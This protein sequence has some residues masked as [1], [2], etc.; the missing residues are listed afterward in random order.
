MK[1][2]PVCTY[3]IQLTP[4]FRFSDA[5]PLMPYFAALGV[6]HIYTSPYLQASPGSTH[7]YDVVDPLSVNE[8][9][10]GKEGHR[11]FLRSLKKEGL[12][13]LIDIVPNHM[14]I[15]GP[16]NRWWWDVLENGPSSPYAAFFDVDW[17]PPEGSMRNRIL[18]PVLEDHYGLV[19]E[20]G[21]VS[22]TREGADFRISYRDMIFPV[23]PRS[24]SGIMERV[25]KEAGHG[26]MLFLAYSLENLP[27]PS[28]TDHESTSLRHRNI[29]VIRE[30]L[31]RLLK[32]EHDLE[33]I[34]DRVIADINE[35]IDAL[36]EMLEKQNYRL[37]FWRKAR[38]DL[39]YRRFF[40]I[41]SLVG[42]RV[43]DERVFRE[44][45]A[46]IISWL[47]EGV[48]D[49]L[50]VDHPDGLRDP[51]EYFSR[52]VERSPDCWIL[53]EK[54]LV[55]GEK[56]RKSWSIH[57][58]TGYDFLNLAGSLFVDPASK[59]SITGFYRKFT[60]LGDTFEKVVIEKKIQVLDEL[61]GSDLNRLSQIFLDI[62]SYYRKYRDYMRHEITLMLKG[63]IASMDVYRT[64]ISPSRKRIAGED[65]RAVL[66]SIR[67]A[68]IN[69]PDIDHGLLS[70]LEDVLLLRKR[71][72]LEGEFLARFQQL[73]GPVMAKGEED[74]GF[75]CYNPLICLN[76]VGGNP[77]DFG[78]SLEA[79]HSAMSQ[80]AFS[81]PLSLLA[82]STHDTKRSEDVRCRIALLSEIPGEW[83]KKVMEWSSM[84]YPLWKGSEPDRNMEYFLYQTL[85]GTWPIS[86]KRLLAYMEKAAREAKVHTSWNRINREY[87]KSLLEF[88]RDTLSNPSFTGDLENFIQR[89]IV[90]GRINSLALTL[91][92]LTLPGV[93]D[94]YQGCEIWN[95][96]LVD[97]DNRGNVDF[98]MLSQLQRTALALEGPPDIFRDDVG[99]SKMWLIM[100]TLELRKRN[101]DIF[102]PGSGYESFQATGERARHLVSFIRGR[103]CLVAV[104]RLSL[105]R[106]SN[107]GETFLVL[108]EGSW[109]NV[110]TG[111]E[112]PGKRLRV[113]EILDSFPVALMCRNRKL[114]NQ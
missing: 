97:P 105:K 75:Y 26:E 92:K 37:S 81:L 41:N 50:R 34:V 76:E 86:G 15:S 28:L 53:A 58:T 18:L 29:R 44:T 10:G 95:F 63:V 109:R 55:P 2:L 59:K 103:D 49:G 104:P 42:L 35:D 107:W 113:D 57:G 108:P 114:D 4:S 61:F 27:L 80:R 64:Y 45:H 12:K 88:T 96:R 62:C 48:V 82:T 70:F 67:N 93:P 68:K 21:L 40:D 60:A 19:L 85:V 83:R 33:D 47:T 22:L 16:Q 84:N 6:S 30:R 99:I 77:S 5:S 13:N 102:G 25:G 20:K 3:R 36:D 52:I 14:A 87:E 38:E 72:G 112:T 69:F 74:T 98:E 90:P 100:K 101:T 78:V 65:R 39:A 106:G 73:T 9:L 7:G 111:K 56:L 89:L 24:I 31:S 54:I 91:L 8:E 17:E 46:L 71:G 11:E 51:Q 23:A 32:K 79:F 94:I 110:F 66:R 43:E 1:E